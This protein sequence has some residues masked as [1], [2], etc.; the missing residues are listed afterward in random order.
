MSPRTG[1]PP[2]GNA[3]KTVALQLKIRPETAET[4]QQCAEQLGIT[5][6]EVVEQ[7]IDLVAQALNDKKK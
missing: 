3:S 2:K 5:R 1:R 4:L 6:T 7:G